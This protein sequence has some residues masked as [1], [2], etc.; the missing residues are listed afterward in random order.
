MNLQQVDLNPAAKGNVVE[1][2]LPEL[3]TMTML[4]PRIKNTAI[5]KCPITH[6]TGFCLCTPPIVVDASKLAACEDAA[7]Y[8]LGALRKKGE[9]GRLSDADLIFL[10]ASTAKMAG[11]WGRLALGQGD[12]R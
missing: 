3:N 7:M 2:V 6:H 11:H 1:M 10:A 9:P 12:L 8:V 5:I 4:L